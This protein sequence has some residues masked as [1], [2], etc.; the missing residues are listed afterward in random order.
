MR[1]IRPREDGHDNQEVLVGANDQRPLQAIL[2][3][4]PV[5]VIAAYQFTIGVV[6]FSNSAMLITVAIIFVFLT[7][8]WIAFA[9]ID[10]QTAKNIAWRQVLLAVVAFIV[11]V[12]GTQPDVMKYLY[13]SWASWVGSIA[14]GIGWLLLPIIDGILRRLGVHRTE[15]GSRS[16]QGTY[17]SGR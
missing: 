1:P 13:P 11:W 3:W 14:L 5:E 4:I 10:P 2:K 17:L 16:N 6:P 8:G 7:A 9:T 15:I 12:V